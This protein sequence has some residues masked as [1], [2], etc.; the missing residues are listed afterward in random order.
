MQQAAVSVW[1]DC[2]FMYELLLAHPSQLLL[3]MDG[4][5]WMFLLGLSNLLLS[6]NE[7]NACVQFNEWILF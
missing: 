2:L 6:S 1:V 4:M 3:S 7:T 5:G